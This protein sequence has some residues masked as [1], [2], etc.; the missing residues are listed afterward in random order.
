MNDLFSTK[1]TINVF[2]VKKKNTLFK[3]MRKNI[4]CLKML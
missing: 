1:K 4:S 2:A 3:N